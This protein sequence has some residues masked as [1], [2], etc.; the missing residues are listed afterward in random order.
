MLVF[1]FILCHCVYSSA[2]TIITIR[3]F[4]YFTIFIQSYDVF[5]QDGIIFNLHFNCSKLL[6]S[7]A[8]VIHRKVYNR[9]LN[10]L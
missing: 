7:M 3:I 1:V 9:I 4:D 10:K 5:I 8:H 6:N 2:V